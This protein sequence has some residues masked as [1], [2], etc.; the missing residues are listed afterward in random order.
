MFIKTV[1]FCGRQ[2]IPLRGHKHYGDF[3]IPNEHRENEGNF[4]E[5]LRFRIDDG[6]EDLKDRIQTCA[7]MQHRNEIMNISYDLIL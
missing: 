7:K 6:D 1:G 5:L 4:G 3:S 2:G